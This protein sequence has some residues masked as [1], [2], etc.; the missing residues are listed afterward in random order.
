MK[1]QNMHI[2][3]SLLHSRKR[4]NT[5]D[6][7]C[8]DRKSM[9][10]EQNT[11]LAI[12]VRTRQTFD[13]FDDQSTHKLKRVVKTQDTR[14]TSVKQDDIALC[15]ANK[16]PKQSSNTKFD[17]SDKLFNS[18]LGQALAL[19]EKEVVRDTGRNGKR[20][21]EAQLKLQDQTVAERIEAAK[22]LKLP[23]HR[24]DE[25]NAIEKMVKTAEFNDDLQVLKGFK[26]LISIQENEQ[27]YVPS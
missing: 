4:K 15:S 2:T 14:S 12:R 8:C 11:N 27:H 13:R 7:S 6:I 1:R 26:R 25:R 20:D 3:H 23:K 16:K 24:E 10:S 22:K 9:P 21:L 5:K 18:D 17:D 19:P